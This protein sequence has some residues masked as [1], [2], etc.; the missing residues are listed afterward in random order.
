MSVDRFEKIL[1]RVHQFMEDPRIS[2]EY[3]RLRLTLWGGEPTLNRPLMERVI[4]EGSKNGTTVFAYTNGSNLMKYVDALRDGNLEVQVSYDGEPVNTMMRLD[5]K[6]VP[7]SRKIIKVMKDLIDEGIK[8]S[9]KST[10]T[11]KHF[12]HLPS[13][14]KTISQLDELSRKRGFHQTY[15]PTIDYYAMDDGYAH[16][17][18]E[19]MIVIGR[20]EVERMKRN[21]PPLLTWIQPQEPSFCSAGTEFFMIN[22]DGDVFPCHG[23]LYQDKKAE[24]KWCSIFDPD[25][26]NKIVEK[27]ELHKRIMYNVPEEC[28][29]DYLTYNVRCNSEAFGKSIETKYEKRWTDYRTFKPLERYFEIIA[30]TKYALDRIRGT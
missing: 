5:K 9:I 15:A 24:M 25:F 1:E 16:D 21:L 20:L 14:W 19:A 10:I 12:I 23:C 17:L 3:D 13:C 30:K 2:S 26:I 28:E 7:T 8:F 27:M 6:G 29:H 11:P 18:R 4:E 22:E